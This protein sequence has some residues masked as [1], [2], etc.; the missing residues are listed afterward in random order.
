MKD[1]PLPRWVAPL[2]IAAGVPLTYAGIFY[3]NIG[4]NLSHGQREIL[5]EES[6]KATFYIWSVILAGVIIVRY[7]RKRIR[8]E[9]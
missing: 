8:N 3:S 9:N 7:T 5:E 1:K 6:G 2:I 4:A